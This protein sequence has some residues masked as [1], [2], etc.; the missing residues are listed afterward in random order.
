MVSSEATIA[1]GLVRLEQIDRIDRGS[2]WR[3][4]ATSE[5]VFGLGNHL[6]R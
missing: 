5:A 4:E 3:P 6:R 2:S 1:M